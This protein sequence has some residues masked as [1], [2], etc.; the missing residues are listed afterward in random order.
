MQQFWLKIHC[1]K[2][3]NIDGKEKPGGCDNETTLKPEHVHSQPPAKRKRKNGEDACN[4]ASQ[5][6]GKAVSH[7]NRKSSDHMKCKKE[8]KELPK[9]LHAKVKGL[10]EENL[11]LF[12]TNRELLKEVQ[13]LRARLGVVNDGEATS[14][15]ITLPSAHATSST[16]T[17]QT[18]SGSNLLRRC[19]RKSRIA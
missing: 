8:V 3:T 15:S 9:E 10:R 18:T 1:L 19:S 17:A 6:E 16:A 5:S 2:V 4:E 12:H 13:T 7:K 11:E 14:Q